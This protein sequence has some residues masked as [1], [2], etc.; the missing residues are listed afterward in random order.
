MFLKGL[1]KEMCDPNLIRHLACMEM[2]KVSHTTPKPECTD[3]CVEA[4]RVAS[5]FR[6]RFCEMATGIKSADADAGSAGLLA[7]TFIHFQSGLLFAY[8]THAAVTA[9]RVSDTWAKF[10][11]AVAVPAVGICL[12]L[13]GT[14]VAVMV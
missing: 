7:R 12:G 9:Y 14:F 11:K 4:F 10:A 5:A 13:T 6:T 8:S 2:C 1:I 3:S